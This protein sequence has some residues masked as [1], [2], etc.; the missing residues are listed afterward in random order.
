MQ[1]TG[2]RKKSYRTPSGSNLKN[3]VK[4][5]RTIFSSGKATKGKKAKC[6]ISPTKKTVDNSQHEFK[7]VQSTQGARAIDL[8]RHVNKRIYHDQSVLSDSESDR[9]TTPPSTPRVTINAFFKVK[10][11]ASKEEGMP[12]D[13]KGGDGI[14]EA[15]NTA[16]SASEEISKLM[17]EHDE[18]EK[19]PL[20]M[21]V[22]VVHAMFKRMEEG[23]EKKIKELEEKIE[24]LS[25]GN[26]ATS[27]SHDTPNMDRV[28]QQLDRL[29][30]KTK[31][32]SSAV[33]NAWED[34]CQ[35]AKRLQKL[36][37]NNTKKTVSI[38]GLYLHGKKYEK[39]RQLEDFF[40]IEV[41]VNPFIEDFYQ[42]GSSTPQTTIVIFQSL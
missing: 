26:G 16:I 10:A 1:A 2:Q 15:Q 28:C 27:K 41:G 22:T 12:K 38:S 11:M 37:L 34:C 39:M 17:K 31:A 35:I 5:T 13:I 18:E 30:L 9:Y 19:G 4:N 33:Q 21:E 40:E 32:V 14:E 25:T 3:K 23:F 42:I 8:E 20:V 29:T 24:H 7:L 6:M 36:E